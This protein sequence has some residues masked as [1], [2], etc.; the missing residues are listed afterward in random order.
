MTNDL[1]YA[2]Y[3]AFNDAQTQIKECGGDVIVAEISMRIIAEL[4]EDVQIKAKAYAKENEDKNNNYPNCKIEYIAKAIVDIYGPEDCGYVENF[5]ILRNKFFHAAFVALIRDAMHLQPTGRQKFGD[6]SR[7]SLSENE[8][9][10][11]VKSLDRPS[12]SCNFGTIKSR[13]TSVNSFLDNIFKNLNPA[14]Y[15]AFGNAKNQL[16]ERGGEAIVVETLMRMI[17][18]K[19]K[20]VRDRIKELAKDEDEQ[21]FWTCRFEHVVKAIIDVFDD[22]L[23]EKHSTGIQKYQILE[24]FRDTRNKLIHTKFVGLEGRE[25]LSDGSRTSLK[26]KEIIEGVKS[27]NRTGSSYNFSTIRILIARAYEVAAEIFNGLGKK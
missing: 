18:E 12:S 22:K 5:G 24:N 10:E 25:I 3:N 21:D 15:S 9:A 6:G 2:E 1:I 19:S 16:G 26:R 14:E 27:L 8:I 11:S 13:I 23:S 7:N 17:A 4:S 20:P